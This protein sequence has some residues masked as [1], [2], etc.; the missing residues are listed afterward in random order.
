MHTA[1][2]VPRCTLKFIKCINITLN[3]LRGSLS[4]S[5]FFFEDFLVEE[6]KIEEFHQI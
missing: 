3:T 2:L 1:Q 4:T 6:F 5:F